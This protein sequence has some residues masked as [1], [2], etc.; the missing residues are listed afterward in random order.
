MKSQPGTSHQT[1]REEDNT[2]RREHVDTLR[3]PAGLIS[4]PCGPGQ[5]GHRRRPRTQV[6]LMTC[7][8]AKLCN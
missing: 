3:G 1:D 6:R 5:H 2:V 8:E 7:E 4:I